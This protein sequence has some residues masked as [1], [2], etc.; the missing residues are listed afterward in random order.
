MFYAKSCPKCVITGITEIPKS[1]TEIPTASVLSRHGF[2]KGDFPE[3]TAFKSYGVKSE[4]KSQYA[5]EFSLPPMVFAH[6]RDQ[7]STGST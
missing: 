1:S 2:K 3:T 7:R 4:R 6:V 5:N